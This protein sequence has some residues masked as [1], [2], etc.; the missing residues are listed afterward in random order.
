MLKAAEEPTHDPDH[1]PNT[2]KAPDPPPLTHYEYIP[3]YHRY[4]EITHCCA[5]NILTVLR[6]TLTKVHYISERGAMAV[7]IT[8]DLS[9]VTYCIDLSVRI[10]AK[11]RR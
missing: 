11:F 3:L 9:N 1:G 5:R 2:Y 7:K 8:C 6:E 10:V 4:T